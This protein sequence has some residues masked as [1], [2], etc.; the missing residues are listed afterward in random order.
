[1]TKTK[2]RL[3]LPSFLIAIGL[4]L[5]RCKPDLNTLHGSGIFQTSPTWSFEAP[6]WII[7]TPVVDD[8]HV[9][10]RT[11]QNVIGVD[12]STGE[13]V[14]SIASQS[15]AQFTLTPM[16]ANDILL[17]PEEDGPVVALSTATGKVIWRQCTQSGCDQHPMSMAVSQK[18]VFV[19]RWDSNVIAYNLVQGDIE[20]QVKLPG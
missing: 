12:L 18:S 2:L 7:T 8:S 6:D 3:F 13:Q 20:W 16:L 11:S 15:R 1:M 5:A 14:W 17:V 4:L 19:A 10:I 9:F